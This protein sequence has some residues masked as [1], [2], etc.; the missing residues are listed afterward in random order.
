MPVSVR[1]MGG[2]F[3]IALVSAATI[4]AQEPPP[5]STT[6]ARIAYYRERL[7]GPGTYP[8]Y[9][10]LGAAYIQKAR[11]TGE[12]EYYTEAERHLRRSLEFQRNFEALLWLGIA[13]LNQHRFQ[14]ALP[15][16]REAVETLPTSIEAQGALFDVYLSLGEDRKAEEALETLRRLQPGFAASARASSLRQYRGDI[17]AAREAM[18]E[19]CARAEVE[20]APVETQAWCQVRLGSFHL[21][22]CDAEGAEAAYQLALEKYADYGLAIEHLAELRATQGRIEEAVS[23]YEKLLQADSDPE[24]RLA[25]AGLL[26]M[27]GRRTEAERERTLALE[28]MRESVSRGEKVYHRPLALRLLGNP[29]TAREGLQLAKQDWENRRDVFAAD[30]LAWAYYITG[31]KER[32]RRLMDGILRS[33]TREPSLLIHAAEV[34]LADGDA[35]GAGR[36]LKPLQSCPTALL[37]DDRAA[38]E[39]LG[40]ALESSRTK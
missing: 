10:R 38:L 7:G 19:A 17:S 31:E 20:S 5:P 9:A 32:A 28:Q 4:L 16:T 36:A 22:A 34:Y 29:Q 13:L 14:E 18:Q 3:L 24:L 11:E 40:I 39:R 12:L 26:E 35:E 30:T 23:L 8:A 37:P 33:G 15:Y 25:L 1:S 21:A 6:D 27:D 2:A